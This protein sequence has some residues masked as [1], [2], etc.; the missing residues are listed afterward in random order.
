MLEF[1]HTESSKSL[2][3]GLASVLKEM[4]LR[5]SI[6]SAKVGRRLLTCQDKTL[7]YLVMSCYILLTVIFWLNRGF[8]VS[9]LVW[10]G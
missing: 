10:S 9:E 6:T 3:D 2:F 1:Q 4:V 5:E 8:S 7:C